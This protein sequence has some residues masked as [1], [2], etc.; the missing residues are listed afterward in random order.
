MVIRGGSPS[1]GRIG[2]EL[3]EGNLM[4]Q[5]VVQM[6]IKTAKGT[7]AGTVSGSGESQIEIERQIIKDREFKLKKELSK[8]KVN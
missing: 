7:K 2:M 3:F 8:I 4:K 6:E 5:E 1:F